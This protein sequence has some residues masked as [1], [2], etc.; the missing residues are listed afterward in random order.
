MA[1]IAP[2]SPRKPGNKACRNGPKATNAPCIHWVFCR[3]FPS[4][5]KGRKFDPT[6]DAG[7]DET[8]FQPGAD[9]QR[10]NAERTAAWRKENE[11]VIAYYDDSALTGHS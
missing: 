1:A 9:W 5:G 8:P 3:A 2:F 4:H 7:D 10:Y 11:S 6:R